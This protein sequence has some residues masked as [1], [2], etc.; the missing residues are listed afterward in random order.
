MILKGD[1][2]KSKITGNIHTI[3]AVGFEG[4]WICLDNEE[5]W[6]LA[7]YYEPVEQ[8]KKDAN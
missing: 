7:E 5:G 3:T 6:R 4:E 1:K 8:E 2:V